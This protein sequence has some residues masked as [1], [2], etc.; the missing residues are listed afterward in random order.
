MTRHM[1]K[2]REDTLIGFWDENHAPE[3]FE[4]KIYRHYL[5]QRY[6][7]VYG[8]NTYYLTI[9]GTSRTYLSNEKAVKVMADPRFKE[10]KVT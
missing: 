8:G 7:E 9:D 4:P 6:E 5:R 2:R 3:G 10:A 1:R